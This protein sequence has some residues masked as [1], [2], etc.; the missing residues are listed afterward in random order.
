MRR[1]AARLAKPQSYVVRQAIKEYAARIG[2]LSEEER[3]RLLH[4][5]DT[6]LPTAPRRSARQVAAELK[7]LRRVRRLPGRL[8]PVE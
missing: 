4:V 6:M 8:H 7:E 5:I 2:R 3:V 1:A